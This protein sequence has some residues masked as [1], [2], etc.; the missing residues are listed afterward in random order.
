MVVLPTP[1][2]PL[3]T[4]SIDEECIRRQRSTLG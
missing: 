4:T 1:G 2:N 3:K